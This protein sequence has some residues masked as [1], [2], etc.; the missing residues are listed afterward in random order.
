M[1]ACL[2]VKTTCQKRENNN[3]KYGF[4]GN[5]VSIKSVASNVILIVR[6]K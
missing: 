4:L 2:N 5:Y 3:E 1:E 6:L